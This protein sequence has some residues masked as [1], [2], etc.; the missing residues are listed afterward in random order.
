VLQFARVKIAVL[1]HFASVQIVVPWQ[2]ASVFDIV[3]MWQ[4]VRVEI[5][6]LRKSSVSYRFCC[7]VAVF[8]FF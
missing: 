5:V 4:S 8:S 7:A 1:L 3:V 2:F 6:M